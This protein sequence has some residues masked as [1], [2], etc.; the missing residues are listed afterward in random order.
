MKTCVR[1]GE[2][3][4]LTAF[5]KRTKNSDKVRTPCKACGVKYNTAWREKNKV[6]YNAYQKAYHQKCRQRD[7]AKLKAARDGTETR[8]KARRDRLLGDVKKT[9]CV[10]CKEKRL[11]C[12]VFH[13]LDPATKESHIAELYS[14]KTLVPE[15]QKCVVMCSNCHRLL[16]A[17]DMRLPDGTEAI[18]FPNPEQYTRIQ[19]GR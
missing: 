18:N 7:P 2:T 17:G 19:R 11:P 8:R 6:A 12:L 9:G 15:L 14:V 4:P 13:H 16:H 3:L 10:C 1:C 5:S